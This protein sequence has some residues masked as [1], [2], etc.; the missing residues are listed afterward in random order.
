MTVLRRHIKRCEQ[1]TLGIAKIT[2]VAVERH[3]A[4]VTHREMRRR[5]HAG[6]KRLRRCHPF[7]PILRRRTAG[8]GPGEMLRL[9]AG[10][11]LDRQRGGLREKLLS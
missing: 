3:M 10:V 2:L 6:R 8:K 7:I 4:F 5:E 9:R 11:R 1:Q